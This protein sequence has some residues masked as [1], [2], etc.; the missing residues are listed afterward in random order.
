MAMAMAKVPGWADVLARY[1]PGAVLASLVGSST[2][3]VDAVDE[4]QLCVRQRLWRACLTRTELETASEVLAAAGPVS[5][6]ELAELL[7]VHYATGFHVTTECSR[8]PN[9]S[10][11]VLNDLG[12]FDRAGETA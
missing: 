10:A 8:V 6:L 9:L 3:V 12:A 11:V 2:L 4:E 5:P 7:R 1:E